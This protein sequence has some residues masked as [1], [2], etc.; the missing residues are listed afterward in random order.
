MT[1]KRALDRLRA[2]LAVPSPRRDILWAHG[3]C[4]KSREIHESVWLSHPSREWVECEVMPLLERVEELVLAVRCDQKSRPKLKLFTRNIAARARNLRN[5]VH[6]KPSAFAP[7]PLL[8]RVK[9]TKLSPEE[10]LR[11]MLALR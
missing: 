7:S 8:N 2:A 4:R 6:G 5:Y 1:P 10:S 3:C 9:G 11:S